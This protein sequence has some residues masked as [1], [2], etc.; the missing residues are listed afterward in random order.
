AADAE[1]V[2]LVDTGGA[3]G[4]II[5]SA[6]NIAAP[7]SSY[8]VAYDRDTNGYVG[9]FRIGNGPI[10]DSCERTDGITA[11]FGSLGSSYPQGVFVCQDNG[12]RNPTANQDFKLT[13]IEKVL[14]A[15]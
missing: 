11:Y 2:T 5:A 12:N 14:A 1:G 4:Y 9:S 7:K 6:Q 13:R 10:A 8:F 3:D 15:L